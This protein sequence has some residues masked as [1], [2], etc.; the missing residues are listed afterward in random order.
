MQLAI[1][2]TGDLFQL[3]MAAFFPPQSIFTNLLKG[4]GK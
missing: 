1:N 3:N 2:S 4:T